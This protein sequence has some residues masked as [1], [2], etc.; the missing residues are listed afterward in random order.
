MFFKIYY[1]SQ[2]NTKNM[3]KL[4]Y[5]GLA[6]ALSSFSIAQEK[7][8]I[9]CAT[10]S[11]MEN[12]FKENPKAKKEYDLFNLELSELTKSGK[13]K[14]NIL[15][16]TQQSKIYE[17]PIVVHII[18]KGDSIG[19]TDNPAD[20]QIIDWI[21]YTNDVFAGKAD[22]V[23]DDTNGGATIP[24]KFVFAKVDPKGNPTN[25]IDRIDLSGNEQFVK[26]GL[27][28][29]ANYPGLHDKEVITKYGWEPTKYYNIYVAHYIASG[30]TVANGYA[31]Y[32]TGD[33]GG[34]RSVMLAKVSKVGEQTMA[35]EFGHGLGLRHTHEGFIAGEANLVKGADGKYLKDE[36]GD[37][38]INITKAAVCPTNNDCTKNGDLVCDTEP[39]LSLY[40]PTINLYRC[41]TGGINQCTNNP[42]AGVEQNI[43][44]YTYCFRNRFTPGQVER[45]LAHLFKYRESL[46]NS[47]VLNNQKIDNN[48]TLVEAVCTP[49]AI[50]SKTAYTIGTINVNFNEINNWTTTFNTYENNFYKDYT[51][52]Y[53][54]A[55]TT[56]NIP[57]D[58]PTKLTLR[59]GD[60][61]NKMTTKVY[62]DYN[63]DGVFSETDEVVFSKAEVL[64]N[65]ILTADITPSSKAVYNKPLRMRIITDYVGTDI[66][67]CNNLRY[68]DAED[69]AVTIVNNL[70]TNDLNLNQNEIIIA[71]SKSEVI[72]KAK[73]IISKI[74]ITD[75]S[76]KLIYSGNNINQ[77]DFIKSLG[78]N[79]QIYIVVVEL[80]NGEKI[81][82]KIIL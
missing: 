33:L 31:N 57:S 45:A 29:S 49:K 50:D 64:Q 16:R 25:G 20:K 2:I 61:S 80:K 63:N 78:N 35:H 12:F 82:K 55:K 68:G 66:K 44:S 37:Y 42:Y 23:L 62:I 48:T 15:S 56:T 40:D 74:S 81:S 43:M 77:K 9:E 39:S 41:L 52:D 34:D 17:I 1:F 28:G 73:N 8:P 13:L 75:I 58:K 26:N 59:L 67:S 4:Y 46:I 24:V 70:V 21:N 71:T 30:T 27:N 7:L 54:L 22:K 72:I 36:N 14:Q 6:L 3:K 51:K 76:G 11:L 79:N 5:L 38:V 32:P 60:T 47:P 19:H 65:E 10:E 69:Y 18:S 53:T